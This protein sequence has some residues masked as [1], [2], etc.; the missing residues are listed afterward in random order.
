MTTDHAAALQRL[1]RLHPK[2][3]D[4]SL[5][6]VERL[7]DALGRPQDRLPPV[8]H[9]AGTNGKGST[10]AF[11][12]AILEAAG[13]TVHVYTSPHLVRFNERIRLGGNLVDDATLARAL[14][15]IEDANGDAPITFFEATTAA[16]FHLFARTPAD[17]LLLEVGLGGRLDATNVIDHPLAGIVT[18]VS[19]DHHDFLGSDIRGI[20][21]EKA[22]IAKAGRPLVIA[23][24]DSADA[25]E[26]LAASARA[27]GAYPFNY[28]EDWTCHLERGRLVYQD[29][30]GLLDLPSPRLPGGHQFINA[31]TAVACLRISGL[32]LPTEA[33]EEGLLQANHAARLQRLTAGSLVDAAP[34]DAEVWLDGGH[35]P[36]AASVLADAMVGLEESVPRPLYLISGL[37]TTKDPVGFFEPFAGLARRVFTV[38][39]EASEAGADPETLAVQASEAGLSATPC[40]SVEQAMERLSAH[41]SN[42]GS[43]RILICGSLYLAGAV[44]QTN[45]ILPD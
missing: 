2:V 39:V 33:I 31:G 43:P 23:P 25:Q 20:A 10:I 4:L 1:T 19:H 6:R 45:G 14:Q 11:L 40:N 42:D 9:V 41:A 22:G 38:P 5:G 28:G 35:N 13:Q 37:L 27:A 32:D 15:T 36:A 26:T 21:R 30:Q 44:L 18:P 29:V 7:L 12:R 3:I 34:P 8:I 24:Q 16:A 17:I